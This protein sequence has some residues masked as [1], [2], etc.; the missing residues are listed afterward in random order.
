MR[1]LFYFSFWIMIVLVLTCVFLIRLLNLSCGVPISFLIYLI[2]I[3]LLNT[4]YRGLSFRSVSTFVDPLQMFIDEYTL[5][6]NVMLL[7]VVFFRYISFKLKSL[8]T[9]NEEFLGVVLFVLLM[10]ASLLVFRSSRLFWIYFGYEI[11]LVPIILIIMIW[12]SYPERMYRGMV[13]LL[14][15]IFFRFPLIRVLLYLYTSGSSFVFYFS[16][17]VNVRPLLLT[18]FSLVVFTSFS[19]KLP[20]YGLH[21]WLPLAHVEAPTFGSILLAGVLLKLGG[22]GVYRFLF[23]SDFSLSLYYLVFSLLFVGIVA[24]SFV[25][26]IQSDI[27]RLI[28]YSSVVHITSVGLALLTGLTMGFKGALIIMV[29]HGISS[30]VMFFIVAEVYDLF[31][32]RLILL[33]RGLYFLR[34]VIFWGM[35]LV[36]FLTVPVPPAFSFLGEVILFISVLSLTSKAF[37]FSFLYIFS[38]VLFNLF[39]LS[40]SFGRLRSK[41][42]ISLT[43]ARMWV[44]IYYPLLGFFLVFLSFIF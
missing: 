18:L 28:A 38:A 22:C 7:I 16:N 29:M 9:L 8:T 40:S 5:T 33:I 44:L 36:F 30:P 26:C 23:Y 39:W 37:L 10:S 6:L 3:L 32:S 13:M 12:G 11:S 27:K 24:S 17:S 1:F 4:V 25:C 41:L 2:F 34:P 42:T 14:Y 15:T 20:I 35:F 43:L 31:G 21:Y 19:V